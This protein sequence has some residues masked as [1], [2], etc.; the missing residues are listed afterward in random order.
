[1]K[2]I[3][4][5]LP[6]LLL[7]SFF[8]SVKTGKVETISLEQLQNKVIKPEDNTLYVVNF[9]ATWCKPC[10]EE[11]PYF[12]E[13]GKKY[14]DKNVR[15][16][17]VSLD[18]ASEKEK[19]SQFVERKSL[20]NQVYLLNAGNPNVWIDKIEPGWDGAIP[21]TLMYKGGQKVF[22]HEGELTLH[23]LE[24]HIQTKNQ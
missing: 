24:Y 23:E 2:I 5:S 9:W 11:L 8:P 15:I 10:I 22:F 16:L 14:A 3:F 19:V 12:E 20:Q 4:F 1:M 7:T 18:F 17:L 6:V 21:A 13:A